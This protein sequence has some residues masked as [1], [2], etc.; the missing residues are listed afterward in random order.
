M[1]ER[2]NTVAGDPSG[3][4][5]T[6]EREHQF[7]LETMQAR[8][9]SG[10][11]DPEIRQSAEYDFT[12]TF[13]Q[14]G[15]SEQDSSNLKDL[16]IENL[17]SGG[18]L[19]KIEK[20][21]LAIIE[22]TKVATDGGEKTLVEILHE[23]LAGRA[24]LIYEQ[25]QKY[26]EGIEGKVIDYGAGDGQVT[27]LLKD[28]S[29][30]DIE[31]YDVRSYPAQGVS[32]PISLFDGG[33]IP[34]EDGHYQAGL[35]TNVAHHEKDNEKILE[36][37]T[38][39]IGSRLVVIETV[40]TGETEEE[41]ARDRERTFLNDYLYNRLFHNANIPVPGTYETPQGWIDRFSQHGWNVTHSED[42][43]FDQPTIRDV[44]HLLVFDR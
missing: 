3:L 40:P 6:A 14:L 5:A 29:G 13:G 43:G 18:N 22:Q 35:M 23:K 2:G 17:L 42:L 8:I 26:F 36:E 12:Y 37:T 25:V 4:E 41:I 38:R 1:D 15:L 20:N 10:L 19:A 30:L 39:A 9:E 44:H 33:K 7:E 32:V 28:R 16:V 34:V 27:Q 11:G 24:E 31:G 21:V